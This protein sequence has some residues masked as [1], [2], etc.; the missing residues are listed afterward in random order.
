[1]KAVISSSFK[2][3]SQ[4]NWREKDFSFEID[5]KNSKLI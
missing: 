3:D 5:S 4:E 1:M 2:E